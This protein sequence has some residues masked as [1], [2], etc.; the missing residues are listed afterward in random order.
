MAT[1]SRP[2]AI[3]IRFVNSGPIETSTT[4][5]HRAMAYIA[6]ASSTPDIMAE[7][8]DGASEWASGSQ[9]CMGARPA[10]VP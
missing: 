7:T 2:K 6:T 10:F 8:V 1:D 9:V 3:N 5:F 4:A